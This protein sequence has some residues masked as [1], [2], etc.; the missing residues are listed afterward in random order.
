MSP[1]G[2]PV[3]RMR[4]VVVE[5]LVVLVVVLV[6]LA[7]AQYSYREDRA[8]SLLVG[9]NPCVS[10]QS[11][12]ECMQV[13]GLESHSLSAATKEHDVEVRTPLVARP[14][15]AGTKCFLGRSGRSGREGK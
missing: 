11:C 5:V 2:V 3:A 9:Q 1:A 10:K 8:S 12:S 14:N 6:S 13:T 4:L 15:V 7:S